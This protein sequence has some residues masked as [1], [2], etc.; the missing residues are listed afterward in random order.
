VESYDHGV[1]GEAGKWLEN[2]SFS[3]NRHLMDRVHCCAP[4]PVEDFIAKDFRACGISTIRELE[5]EG[6]GGEERGGRR[7][8]EG[9]R[10]REERG[11]RR[12]GREEEGEG[13][14][15]IFIC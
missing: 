3:F 13:N 4:G 12:R 15:V 2:D 14:R 10:G 1:L 6:G 9:G 5:G 8:K 7:E 11:G